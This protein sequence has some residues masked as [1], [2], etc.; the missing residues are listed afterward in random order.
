MTGLYPIKLFETLSSGVPAVVTDFPGMADLVREV[1]GGVVVPRRDAAALAETVRRLADDP[2]LVRRLGA[3][4]R[5][6]ILDAH[7]WDRRAEATA[8]L[9]AELVS[10]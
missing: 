5:R 3:N 6:A 9:L 4:G 10:R 1:E 8:A 2:D 7:S